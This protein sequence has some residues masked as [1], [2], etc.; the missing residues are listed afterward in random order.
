MSKI[1]GKNIFNRFGNRTIYY[2]EKNNFSGVERPEVRMSCTEEYK[3]HLLLFNK[4]S[5]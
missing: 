3:N 5:Q 4:I 2:L 1:K